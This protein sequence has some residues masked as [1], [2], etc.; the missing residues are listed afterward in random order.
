MSICRECGEDKTDWL[1]NKLQ[2][3]IAERD[4]VIAKA[5]EALTALKGVVHFGEKVPEAVNWKGAQKGVDE[6]LADIEAL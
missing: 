4:A 1:A 3:E 6:A 5:K 2:K